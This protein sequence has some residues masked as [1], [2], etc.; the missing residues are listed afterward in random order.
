M[1]LPRNH[2]AR[3]CIVPVMYYAAM[4]CARR[5]TLFPVKNHPATP[6]K[7]RRPVR[8]SQSSVEFCEVR[9]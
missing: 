6:H 4:Y 7:T 5:C 9:V 3:S 1:Q 8:Y 2:A